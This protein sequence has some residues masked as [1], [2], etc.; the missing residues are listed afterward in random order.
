MKEHHWQ[1]IAGTVPSKANQYKIARIGGHGTL[2]KGAALK[3]YEK[4]FY[5][6]V[7]DYRNLGIDG[8]FEYYARVYYPSMRSDLD[9][10][11]KVQLDCLQ[12]TGT[13]TND[14]KC[15]K[16]VAEKF[17]DKSNP[18]VEFKIIEIDL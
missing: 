7:G 3:E 9:N 18:R 13:I 2:I 4:N 11:L 8:Y 12:Q 17:I 16:I 6:Q 5:M 1:T 15:V 10:S 14:N